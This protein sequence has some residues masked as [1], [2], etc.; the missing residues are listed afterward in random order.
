MSSVHEGP[1]RGALD[2]VSDKQTRQPIKQMV[3]LKQQKRS[4]WIQQEAR[5][6]SL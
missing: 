2:D 3:Q 5:F 4:K 1:H 6:V